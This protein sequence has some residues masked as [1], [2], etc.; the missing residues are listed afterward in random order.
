MKTSS[1][2]L[3]FCVGLFLFQSAQAT[4]N[5]ELTQGVDAA[6][7]I[8][9]V[10][11]ANEQSNVPDETTLTNVIKNDLQNS[12]LFRVTTPGVLAQAPTQASDVNSVYWRKQKVDDVLVGQVQSLGENQFRVHY[13][14]VG[15]VNSANKNQSTITLL[16]QNFRVNQLGLRDLAHHI[17]DEIYQKLTG[18]RGVFSTK[19]AYILVQR[20]LDKPTTYLLEVS[21]EDGFNPRPLLTSSQPIMSPSW[22]PNGRDIAYVSF[23]NQEARIFIQDVHTGK[24][25]VLSQFPGVN[26][27]PAFSPNGTQ[28]ALV[29]TKTGNPNIYLMNLQSQ[30][31]TPLTNDYSIDTE[32]AWAPDGKSMLFTS[33]R[34]GTPQIYRYYFK[35]DRV[36]RLTFDGNYNARA[37]FTPDEQNIIMMHRETGLF[38][39]ASQ[40]LDSGRVFE[41]TQ[42]GFDE[43]PSLAPNGKMVLYATQY[44]GRNVLAMVSTDGRIKL[45]LPAREGSVQEPAWSPFI[46]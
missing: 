9:I 16:N 28:M 33:N 29:L 43:S 19:L 42:S 24:R 14:L 44:G 5:L 23:E 35:N 32:P 21:D 36:Q 25:Q 2:L 39:I 22:T 18:I 8:A 12:G 1:V 38:G 10:P 46:S 4:L 40:N 11:F 45:R 7:P 37:S 41:L 15:V 30:R 6:I 34:G 27:A 26:G 20:R 31:L 3:S 17:S 13:Q